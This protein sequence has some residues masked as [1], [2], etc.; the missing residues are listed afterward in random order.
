MRHPFPLKIKY[1]PLSGG[2]DLDLPHF[3]GAVPVPL[4]VPGLVAGV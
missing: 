1:V 4:S 2:Q 3:V